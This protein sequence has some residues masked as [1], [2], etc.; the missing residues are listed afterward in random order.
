ME[1]MTIRRIAAIC[2][3][4]LKNEEQF[5]SI[6][7]WRQI[8]KNKAEKPEVFNKYFFSVFKK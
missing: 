6:S 7:R 3:L 2:L 5:E 4:I 8:A 1:V